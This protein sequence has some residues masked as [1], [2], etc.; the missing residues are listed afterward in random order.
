MVDEHAAESPEGV[1]R[2]DLLLGLIPGV[3][4]LGLAAQALVSVSLPVV[5]VL[6][7]LLAATGLFDALVVHPPA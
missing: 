6:S 4:A 3:Y 5:L 1:S 7:S 2:Y